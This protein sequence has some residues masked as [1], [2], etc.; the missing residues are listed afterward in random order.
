M[1]KM[2]GGMLSAAGFTDFCFISLFFF[3]DLFKYKK[4]PKASLRFWWRFWER[5][6]V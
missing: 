1:K 3:D 4:T 5:R 6:T 2:F